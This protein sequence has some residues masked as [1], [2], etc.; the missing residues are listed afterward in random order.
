MLIEKER[1]L[2]LI[3]QGFEDRIRSC[4]K[5]AALFNATHPDRNPISKSTVHKIVTH[6]FEIETLKTDLATEGRNP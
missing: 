5:I 1:T 2:L 4:Q 3:Y 6:F